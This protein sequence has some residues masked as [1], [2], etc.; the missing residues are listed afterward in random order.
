[1]DKL[2]GGRW[3]VSGLVIRPVWRA[4]VRCGRV[5]ASLRESIC[6]VDGEVASFGAGAD[7]MLALIRWRL[8]R[9]EFTLLISSLPVE[10]LD[11]VRHPKEKGAF[12]EDVQ[13]ASSKQN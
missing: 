2:V 5:P 9:T 3:P 12:P 7:P 10:H 4:A 8:L 1:M 13:A 6:D 11:F